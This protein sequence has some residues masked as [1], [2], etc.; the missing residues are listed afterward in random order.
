MN[1]PAASSGKLLHGTH[2]TVGQQE[3]FSQM[4]EYAKSLGIEFNVKVF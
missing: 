3:V 4:V 2:G 1:N